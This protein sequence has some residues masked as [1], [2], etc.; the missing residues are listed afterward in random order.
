MTCSHHG[1][2]GKAEMGKILQT[3]D[4]EYWWMMLF[5]PSQTLLLHKCFKSVNWQKKYFF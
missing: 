2:L 1:G 4:V 5:V 3:V